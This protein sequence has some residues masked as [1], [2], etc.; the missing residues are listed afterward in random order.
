M[1][2]QCIEIAYALNTSDSHHRRKTEE[3]TH[4]SVRCILCLMFCYTFMGPQK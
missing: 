2:H 3:E 1:E 4:N